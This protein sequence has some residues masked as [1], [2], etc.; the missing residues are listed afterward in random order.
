MR[1][2]WF[3]HLPRASPRSP[4]PARAAGQGAPPKVVRGGVGGFTAITRAAKA[5]HRDSHFPQTLCAARSSFSI[6]VNID[7]RTIDLAT[8]IQRR[9]DFT[10]HLTG[11]ACGTAVL[12]TC[13]WPVPA[14]PGCTWPP[15]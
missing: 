11:F 6:H 5:G 8:R 2:G 14:A 4:D 15:C 13:S 3:R 7:Q 12:T 1:G 10:A 9:H